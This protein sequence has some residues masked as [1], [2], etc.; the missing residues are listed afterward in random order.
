MKFSCSQYLSAE[1]KQLNK[2][3]LSLL[4][5]Q[6]KGL[7]SRNRWLHQSHD[8]TFVGQQSR[9]ALPQPYCWECGFVQKRMRNLGHSCWEALPWRRLDA[10]LTPCWTHD[11]IFTPSHL[12]CVAT[13]FPNI[14][15]KSWQGSCSRLAPDSE[16]T[17]YICGTRPLRETLNC[18]TS[19]SGQILRQNTKQQVCP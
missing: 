11:S 3:N 4:V 9:K 14:T 8:S 17:T 15:L 1:V 16:C 6:V 13:D 5:H 12:N 2:A 10:E 7:R 18:A 19:I